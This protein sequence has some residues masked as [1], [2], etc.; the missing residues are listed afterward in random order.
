MDQPYRGDFF[1]LGLLW[2]LSGEL[3]LVVLNPIY[4]LNPWPHQVV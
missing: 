2:L 4:L 1:V 3:R